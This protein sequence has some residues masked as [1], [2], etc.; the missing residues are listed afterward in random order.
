MPMFAFICRDGGDKSEA[1]RTHL[2]EHL[3]YVESIVDHMVVGGPCP[4]TA[5][6]DLRQFEA[7]LMVYKAETMSQARELLENDPYYKNKIWDSVETLLFNP[8]AGTYIGGTT[9]DIVDGQMIRKAN[10][11]TAE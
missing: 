2:I 6:F 3:R 7:S 8:V 10:A 9:W 11:Q 4:P 5:P 1:R